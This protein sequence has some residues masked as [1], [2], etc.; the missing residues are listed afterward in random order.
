MR[1]MPGP[2]VL[3]APSRPIVSFTFDDAP[4][5]AWEHGAPILEAAG[6][7]GTFYLSGELI[8]TRPE[9]QLMSPEEAADL[10]ARGHEL[11]CHTFAH[12]KLAAMKQRKLAA[13]LD[14]NETFLASLDGR[15]SQRNFAVPF[16]MA[17]PLR[18]K[19]LQTR[20]RSSRSG[21]WGI[22]RG[23]TNLHYLSAVELLEEALD[24][25][26]VEAWLDDLE[27]A[28]GWLIL[29]TH[30]I[31][32]HPPGGFGISSRRFAAI[33]DSVARRS[34]P[35]LSVDAALDRLN[36]ATSQNQ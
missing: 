11:G 31:S 21:H 32:D 35:I 5:T 15:I 12:P 25:T 9:L 36:L 6:G 1:I 18:Q 14:R 2:R 33:V 34:L 26:G 7:R 28:P 19:L 20:F 23:P 8:G 3:V 27:R 13:D 4:H 17:T 29:F 30:H 16:G 10:A 24:D 22:N